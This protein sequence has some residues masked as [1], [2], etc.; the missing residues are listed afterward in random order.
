M[1]TKSAIIGL[2][3][4]AVITGFYMVSTQNALSFSKQPLT[5]PDS[6]LSEM[7]KP[8][9]APAM[10]MVNIPENCPSMANSVPLVFNDEHTDKTREVIRAYEMQYRDGEFIEE[11]KTRYIQYIDVN[12]DGNQDF[13]TLY[14]G[15]N[16]CGSIGCVVE[17][18]TQDAN[19]EYTASQAFYT[20]K[21][22]SSYALQAT[23]NG[24]MQMITP[25]QNALLP[26]QQHL[27]KWTGERYEAN[28]YCL[29][30]S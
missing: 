11:G 20:T 7:E 21:E 23:H 24:Y 2:A 13:M 26:K 30:G 8:P 27:W 14:N 6:D 4:L 10:T 25:V 3:G 17:V 16:W 28:E 9:E 22:S 29:N 5:S 19:G 18:F 12:N 15:L 1:Q